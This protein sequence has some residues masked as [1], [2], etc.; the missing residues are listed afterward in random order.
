MG[1]IWTLPAKP[2][3]AEKFCRPKRYPKA[4]V[5]A[6]PKVQF[7]DEFEDEDEHDF[8]APEITTIEKHE[9]NII[10]TDI[11]YHSSLAF[12]NLR[13]TRSYRVGSSSGRMGF[14]T[15]FNQ[16]YGDRT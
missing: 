1:V 2:D 13:I 6:Q 5:A 12:V 10:W 7:E 8:P 9:K 15:R 14:K 4:S 3:D 16:P 11:P